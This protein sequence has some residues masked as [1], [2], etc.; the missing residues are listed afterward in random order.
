MK[1][2][3]SDAYLPT[4]SEVTAELFRLGPVCSKQ[5]HQPFSART[6][7][8]LFKHIPC[9]LVAVGTHVVPF[10]FIYGRYVLLKAAQSFGTS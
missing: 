5:Q 9:V 7:L 6:L 2:Q 10:L 4:T 8:F 1:W 3:G